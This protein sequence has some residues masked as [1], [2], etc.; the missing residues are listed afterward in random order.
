[1]VKISWDLKTFLK[2]GIYIVNNMMDNNYF[3]KKMNEYEKIKSDLI[4][5]MKKID[6][7]NF[8][9]INNKDF[10]T[11]SKEFH[12]NYYNWWGFSQVSE[13]ITHTAEHILKKA[14]SKE[15]MIK[16]TNPTKKS[17][18]T[19]EEENIYKIASKIKKD[20]NASKIFQNDSNI[21][22]IKKIPNIY[23][24]IQEHQKKFFWTQNNF[25]ETKILS[26]NYYISELKELINKNIDTS[27]LLKKNN[28]RFE[29][30]KKNRKETLKNLH[31]HEKYFSLTK[32]IDYFGDYQDKRKAINLKS[33]YYLNSLIDELSRRT[34]IS[35]NL[36]HSCTPYEFEKI[37]NGNFDISNL[38][39]RQNHCTLIFDNNYREILTKN[40]SIKKEIEI[41]GKKNKSRISE[42]EGMRSQG[43]KITGKITK[44]LD[45]RNS[46]NF[47]KGDILVTTMTSPDFVT[48]M[49]KAAAIVT[50]E[51]GITCHAAVISRELGIP[52]VIGTRI[53]TD[54]LDNGDL[55]EVNANHGIIKI[56]EKN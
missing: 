37:L 52:C 32:L 47:K 22:L 33:H 24:L 53:A 42:F 55:V 18:T 11:I 30:L 44:I 46:K 51:G 43:G 5:N 19:I 1:M 45:P 29:E 27:L 49:K 10:L 23:K 50:D 17:Y 4:F 2:N 26:I 9:K 39:D 40:N 14:V 35:K 28:K 8:K 56:L 41:F 6:D 15:D 34:G 36:L 48:L 13:L 3:L 31:L 21:D 38:S 16:I 25:Y 54:V 12:K 20:K 7:L